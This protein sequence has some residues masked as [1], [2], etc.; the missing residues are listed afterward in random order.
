MVQTRPK[1]PL[2]SCSR[3]CSNNFACWQK[4][5]YCVKNG[6]KFPNGIHKYS[7]TNKF[8]PQNGLRTMVMVA[9][10][11]HNNKRCQEIKCMQRTNVIQD[12]GVIQYNA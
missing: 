7:K 1:M 5:P 11:A 3:L 6:R 10:D 9:I 2:M 8:Q 12:V 4:R